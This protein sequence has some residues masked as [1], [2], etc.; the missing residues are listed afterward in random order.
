MKEY[1]TKDIRNVA[2]VGHTG[3]GKTILIERL[4][5]QTGVTKRMGNIHNGSSIMDF[6]DE[7]IA[8]QSSI[9][10]SIACFERNNVKVNL[11]D[12][13]G[14]I[15]FVGEMNS[16]LHV[17]EGALVLVEAVSGV[18]VGTELAWQEITKRNMPKVLVINRMDRENVRVRRT[19]ESIN[20]SLSGTF[21]QMQIPL[22]EG[23][24]FRG[25]VDVLAMECRLGDDDK[26]EPI[27]AELQAEADAARLAVVEA[28]AL[29]DEAL[30][31]K[32]F[33]EDFLSDEEIVQ[34]LRQAMLNGEIIPVLYSAPEKG[35]A[36]LPVL[37]AL[38]RLMP[39]PNDVEGPMASRINGEP[40]E[41]DRT[42]SGP[43][44][45]FVFKT[46]DNQYGKTS[47]I[48][49]YGGSLKSDSRVLDVET[50]NEVRVGA[51]QIMHGREQSSIKTLH[52]GDIGAVVKLGDV[53]TNGTL[54][55][56]SHP[57]RLPAISQPGPITQIAIH[58]VAQSDVAKMSDSLNRLTAEDLTLKWYSETSTR[59]TILAGMGTTHLDIA[60]A[61]AKSKYGLNLKTTT[62][63]IP[64]KE[65]ILGQSK[66]EYTHKKQSGGA[67][68]YAR[69]LLR[70]EAL[71]D[72]Q[73]FEFGSEIFGGAISAPF[74]N[75][76]EKG[77]RT[78]LE[79][80]PLAG[81]PVTGVRAIVLD[82][83]EHPVDSKEIAFQTAG[84]EA[85][86]Q[87]MLQAQPTLLEPI[88]DVTVTVPENYMG[89]ILGDMNGRRGRVQGMDSV[90]NRSIIKA[91]VPLSEMLSYSA[92]LRSLT[93]GRGIYGMTF[94]YY[95]EV[96]NHLQSKIKSAEAA[97]A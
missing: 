75:A 15:D 32:Y 85:F 23:A 49:V 78:A 3:S 42:E 97:Q 43:L 64:Y 2:I 72:D 61:K 60:V 59:E 51:L 14:Y 36:V 33:E 22:G 56:P 8:R 16:S 48:R 83:K 54:S 40:T 38:T 79:S 89:D 11:L 80:G 41:L 7:E 95:G 34:G 30:M 77:C 90:G 17:A 12:T 86:R 21:V 87:A 52:A 91:E 92:D 58:P 29:G 31:E 74:V 53:A 44:S 84:R 24:D 96:P 93:G 76:T 46:R 37:G 19:M 69:V 82:G 20:E 50:G 26:R 5:F 18:E 81:Y 47:Y 9:S 70:L 6:E 39:A 13:P 55:A 25:V 65:T 94:S 62:P 67:G 68:Q 71:P 57:H 35:I 27:P 66:A 28:A 4:L 88:Y 45:A 1:L 73:Q 10:T 63:K